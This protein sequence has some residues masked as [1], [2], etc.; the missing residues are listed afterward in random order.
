MSY[1]VAYETAAG[2]RRGRSRGRSCAQARA[3]RRDDGPLTRNA[4]IAGTAL[5]AACIVAAT[6]AMLGA[7]HR[8][9]SLPHYIFSHKA[10]TVAWVDPEYQAQ[11]ESDSRFA[12]ARPA[13][14]IAA[15]DAQPA[16]AAIVLPAQVPLP[17]A[18][19][20]ITVHVA[21]TPL[22]HARPVEIETT[23]S[24]GQPE[25]DTAEASRLASDVPLMQPQAKEEAPAAQ[26]KPA[27]RSAPAMAARTTPQPDLSPPLT[28]LAYAAP[29]EPA[30]PR[31][32]THAPTVAPMLPPA[33]PVREA[34]VASAPATDAPV[35]KSLAAIDRDAR[36]SEH[37]SSRA[38][39]AES[40]SIFSSLFNSG[41]STYERLYGK[42]RLAS[43]NPNDAVS[44]G[45]AGGGLPRAPYDRYTAVYIIAQKK[46]YLPDGTVL[47]AHSGLGDKMDDPR[48]V[49]VRMRGATPPHVYDL[50]MRETLFHGVEAIRMLPIGGE[51]AIF[52]R[53]GILAH[54][55]MLGPSG[56]SNGC[57]SFRDYETFLDAFKAGKIKRMAVIARLD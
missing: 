26:P 41:P 7:D 27:P 21:A 23:G 16:R 17:H 2:A 9:G 33:R 5:A 14:K 53:D 50:K 12:A 24:L 18:R 8:L 47:E 40:K 42:V 51:D 57:V 29:D 54:T 13:A 6:G 49:N 36:A 4:L 45:G 15:V 48:Y 34:P 32:L 44:D 43:L 20:T 10:M 25:Q 37:R 3:L 52:G 38:A 46:V 55:Y 56:Q 39:K 22:P 31:A 1:C 19:P 30:L 11:M 35:R 28:R